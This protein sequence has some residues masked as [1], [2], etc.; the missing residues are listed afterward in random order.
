VISIL[1][2]NRR[3]LGYYLI[4]PVWIYSCIIHPVTL[5]FG[6]SGNPGPQLQGG[7]RRGSYLRS[8]KY[9]H[10]HSWLVSAQRLSFSVSCGLFDFKQHIAS[11]FV[12]SGPQLRRTMPQA[13]LRDSAHIKDPVWTLSID[14]YECA[15][16]DIFWMLP[17]SI[18]RMCPSDNVCRYDMKR[19]GLDRHHVYK[20]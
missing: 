11:K 4:M 6:M 17:L 3:I 1:S 8:T 5:C 12:T 16:T 10:T 20:N 19:M 13:A 7:H 18:A 2:V 15:A 14:R 9:V